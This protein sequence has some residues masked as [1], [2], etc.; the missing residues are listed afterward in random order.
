LYDETKDD[1]HRFGKTSGMGGKLPGA[2]PA[3]YTT[4]LA[5]L[6]ARV[7]A[8]QLRA[9]LSVNRE[10]ILLYWD[11][12]KIIAEAQKTKGYGKQVVERLAEDLQKEFPGTA[13]FSPQ[14]V[15]FMRSFYLAWSA[16]PQKLSQ[17]VREPKTA[18]LSQTGTYAKAAGIYHCPADQYMDPTWHVQRVRSCSMNLQF[19][20]VALPGDTTYGAGQYNGINYKEFIKY[21][22]F[23]RGGLSASDCFVFLDENPLSLNDGRFLYILDGSDINDRP[24]INHGH[25]SSFSFA[26]GHAE[27]QLW[28]DV[29]LTSDSTGQERIR[30]GSHNMALTP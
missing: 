13:G 17:V 2:L 29:F 28:H 18:I 27:L 4:L 1:S 25:S 23:G 9:V 7:R 30:Y 19:G 14:N 22:D 6:K 11:I 8:A 16:M 21:S 12:E 3:G 24:A 15:W 20:T 10:L 5:D 26:D